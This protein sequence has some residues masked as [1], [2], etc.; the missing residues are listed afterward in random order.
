MLG[1]L[2]LLVLLLLLRSSSNLCRCTMAPSLILTALDV[3]WRRGGLSTVT[4]LVVMFVGVV[5]ASLASGCPIGSTH[6]PSVPVDALITECA[7]SPIHCRLLVSWGATLIHVKLD[8]LLRDR[9]EPVVGISTMAVLLM[10]LKI[11]LRGHHVVVVSSLVHAEVSLE[12]VLLTLVLFSPVFD[13]VYG[14]TTR[15]RSVMYV[16]VSSHDKRAI[17]ATG[18][19]VQHLRA[20]C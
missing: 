12:L 13:D 14:F 20:T 2:V 6:I 16:F 11:V 7:D 10:M 19:A 18:S 1:L 8:V 3:V 15:V 4:T 9:V 17:G 5:G